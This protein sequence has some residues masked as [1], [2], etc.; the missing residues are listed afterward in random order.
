MPRCWMK[1]PTNVFLTITAK[2]LNP[3]LYV[4]AKGATEKLLIK[5]TGCSSRAWRRENAGKS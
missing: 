2:I 4:V 5:L 3:N 1:T